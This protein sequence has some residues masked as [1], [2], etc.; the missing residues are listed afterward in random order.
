[1]DRCRTSK[2]I[3]IRDRVFALYFYCFHNHVVGNGNE[4]KII[5]AI[6]NCLN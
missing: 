6:S 2:C 5:I 4:S 3:R 1:L